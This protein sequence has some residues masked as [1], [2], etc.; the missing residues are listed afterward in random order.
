VSTDQN[1][2]AKSVGL[3]VIRT[4]MRAAHVQCFPI[5]KLLCVPSQGVES[6]RINRCFAGCL[7]NGIDELP[8]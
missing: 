3:D 5:I 6:L 4:G 1:V 2:K 8:R 7:L